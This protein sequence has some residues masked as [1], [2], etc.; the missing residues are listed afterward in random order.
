M[1]RAW[2]AGTLAVLLG[3]MPA[4]ADTL[5]V[6][7]A[8]PSTSPMLP[9]NVGA[10]EGLFARHGLDVTV[11]DFSGGGK[12]HQAMIAGSIDLGV[13]SGPELALIA[14]GAPELAVANMVPTAAG[15]GIVVGADSPV[16][17]LADLKGRRLGVSSNGSLTYWLAL[18]LAR[19]Q[20]WSPEDLRIV[21]IGGA[22]PGVVA[23]LR[24]HAIDADISATSLG[25][26][27][28][29]L[30]Q[31]RLLAPV[32]DYEGNLCGG[33]I[34]ATNE[35]ISKN[36]EEIRRFLVA[37]FDVIAWMRTHKAETVAIE[38]RVTGFDPG[39][40]GR[41]YDLTIGA[42]STT[43]RF[44]AE[45]LANLQRSFRD[46]KLVDGPVDMQ[47]LYTERFLPQ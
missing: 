25:F 30:G 2:C 39:V 22:T 6:G 11:E 13:G 34:Y 46:L 14:K 19:K 29:R 36:P 44:D 47:R 17:S 28:E 43:G 1:K 40:M 27:L 41:E 33:T 37:W 26:D 12:L 5:H 18:E 10:E 31:G 4:A 23:A 45:S 16:H 38:S 9:M 3:G 24:A 35:L 7:K 21:A 8:S 42:F 15:I 32:N 20:G